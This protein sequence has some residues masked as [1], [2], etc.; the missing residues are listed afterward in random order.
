M[1]NKIKRDLAMRE[2]NGK[3]IPKK[4]R[5]ACAPFPNESYQNDHGLLKTVV[6]IILIAS[7]VGLVIAIA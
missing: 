7:I 1:T 3:P 2:W 6:L 4:Y 5:G